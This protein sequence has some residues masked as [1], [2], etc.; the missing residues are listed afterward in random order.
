MVNLKLLKAFL[1]VILAG[2]LVLTACAPAG[3]ELSRDTLVQVSTIDAVMQGI[4][5]GVLT[6]GELKRYG[7]FGIGTVEA[8][9]GEV[10]GFDGRY[11]QIRADGKVYEITDGMKTPFASV[12][13]FSAD[14]QLA[15]PAGLDMATLEKYLDSRLPSGNMLYAIRIDGSFSYMKT[16]SVP[17]QPKPYP[18]LTEVTKNQPVFEFRDI[19][20][21]IAGFRAPP[22]VKGINVTGYH[23]HFLTKDGKA[24]GHVLDFTTRDGTVLIDDTPD[25]LIKL[26]PPDNPFYRIDLSRDL[27]ADV[28]RAEK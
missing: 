3:P 7:D 14:R 26:P 15:L 10:I 24:G 20:G 5:D 27:S 16:R 13:F 25:F 22:Y 17:A 18:P 21:T 4:Y 2:L 8:L 19:E 28:R 9:D 11:W 1:P 12:T 6:F 23:L